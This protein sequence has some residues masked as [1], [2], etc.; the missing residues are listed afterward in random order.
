[1]RKPVL[2]GTLLLNVQIQLGL[3]LIYRKATLGATGNG[4]R[5]VSIRNLKIRSFISPGATVELGAK[6]MRV[7]GKQRFIALSATQE[8]R[9]VAAASME[10]EL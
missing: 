1:P 9:S 8:G 6:L 10:V 4:P 2:P 7:S 5:K 3:R